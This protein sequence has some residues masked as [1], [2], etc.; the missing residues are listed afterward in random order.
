MTRQ[1]VIGAVRRSDVWTFPVVAVREAV[2][3]AAVHADYAQQ[4]APIRVALFD[5][6]LEVE[7]PGLLPVPSAA[8]WRKSAVDHRIPIAGIF[9]SRMRP[10]KLSGSPRE[11]DHSY[12]SASIGLIRDAFMAG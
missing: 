11:V 3:N 9:W 5:D 2:M 7:N 6:R 10:D 12:R 8:W 1:A 4:G